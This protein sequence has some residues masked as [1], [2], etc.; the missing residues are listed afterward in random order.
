MNVVLRED[1][2]RGTAAAGDAPRQD[3]QRRRTGNGDEEEE[4][5]EDRAARGYG[6]SNV[7]KQHRHEGGGLGKRD[8]AAA[9]AA[10]RL[11]YGLDGSGATPVVDNR[12]NPYLRRNP[13]ERRVTM[14]RKGK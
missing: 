14:R 1:Q 9:A 3:T 13:N 6:A 12:G 11:G 10:E 4:E 5:E 7:F 8:V 2:L